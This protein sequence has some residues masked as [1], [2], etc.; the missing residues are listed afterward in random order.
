METL[1]PL[2]TFTSALPG[3]SVLFCCH[4][5]FCYPSSLLF[6]LC[7][8]SCLKCFWEG[9][10]AAHRVIRPARLDFRYCEIG[11][12]FFFGHTCCKGPTEVKY[13]VVRNAHT[14]SPPNL[15]PFFFCR[16]P[17]GQADYFLLL[18]PLGIGGP[19]EQ[20]SAS[21]YLPNLRILNSFNFF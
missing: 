7:F 18:A 19:R 4:F 2:V 15:P 11:H 16:V 3:L 9:P 14:H 17:D 8:L 12:V 21:L 5:A 20:P 1:A 6:F 13:R 10:L